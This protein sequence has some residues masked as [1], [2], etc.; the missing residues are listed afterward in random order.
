MK[1]FLLGAA[2]VVTF[3]AW[4]RKQRREA[5]AERETA[6]APAPREPNRITVTVG[7]GGGGYSPR[8]APPAP[9]RPVAPTR[10]SS[11][12]P[13]PPIFP[14]AGDGGTLT[15]GTPPLAPRA[16]EFPNQSRTGPG[17]TRRGNQ[18]TA[19]YEALDRKNAGRSSSSG[20]A[21]YSQGGRESV[22]EH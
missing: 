3:I 7:G 15:A 1:W 8:M 10:P 5:L 9:T 20:P 21:F 17:T 4:R 19:F 14:R 6:P 16:P 22:L 2:V 12:N 13:K 11:P 18:N